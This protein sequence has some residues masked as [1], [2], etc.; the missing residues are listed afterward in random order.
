MTSKNP[1]TACALFL[2]LCVACCAQEPQASDETKPEAHPGVGEEL[3][4]L[5]KL[6]QLEKQHQDGVAYALRIAQSQGEDYKTRRAKREAIRL[7]GNWRVVRAI[8]LL[9]REIDFAYPPDHNIAYGPLTPY[10]AAQALVRIGPPAM[11]KLLLRPPATEDQ[12]TLQLIAWVIYGIEGKEGG[13]W[14]LERALANAGTRNPESLHTRILT[15]LVQLIKETDFENRSQWP[16]PAKRANKY[17]LNNPVMKC[18]KQ[19]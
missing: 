12:D 1:C 15:R 4:P 13:L 17:L 2:V 10:P 9:I 7:L 11:E 16:R 18:E 14:H 3:D 8:D 5:L 6:A 19:G